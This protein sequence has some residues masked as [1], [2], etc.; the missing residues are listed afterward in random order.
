MAYRCWEL[1]AAIANVA[2]RDAG[3]TYTQDLVVAYAR[4]PI[5]EVQS[6]RL[7]CGQHNPRELE[8]PLCE[9][10]WFSGAC[11]LLLFLVGASVDRFQLK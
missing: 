1:A 9:G 3:N 7:S 11:M 8:R 6:E 2:E 10:Q 5:V 4:I